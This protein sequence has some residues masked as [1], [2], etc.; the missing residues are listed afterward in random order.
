MGEES[1][2]GCILC[3]S[4]EGISCRFAHVEI[5]HETVREPGEKYGKQLQRQR[6]LNVVD[7]AVC[8][9]CAKRAKRKAVLWTIPITL[10]LTAV[11][12]F[13]SLFAVRP[14]RNI[15]KEVASYPIVLPAVAVI[16]WLLGLSVYLPKPAM[17]YGAEQA[18]KAL[19][20]ENNTILV[21]LEPALYTRKKD[22][23]IS[24]SKLTGSSNLCDDL[25]KALLPIMRG[26]AGEE[27]IERLKGMTFSKVERTRC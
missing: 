9:R 21:P 12:T 17:I 13:F 10:V 25:A 22:G 20:A 7:A 19:G 14:N 24:L 23:E 11:L 16:L 3:G 1:M 18:R 15:R 2:S 6:L 26:E 4:R 8:P 5:T 27:E